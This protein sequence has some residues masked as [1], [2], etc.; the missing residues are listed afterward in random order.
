MSIERTGCGWGTPVRLGDEVNSPDDELYPSVGPHGTLYF[1]SGPAAP[2]A[3]KHYDI[4]AARPRGTGRRTRPW[5]PR[6][7][8]SCSPP[9]C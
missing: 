2:G 1:A 4:F 6:R 7:F 5:P 3:G 8:A 9:A